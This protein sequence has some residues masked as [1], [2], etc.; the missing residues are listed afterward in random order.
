MTGGLFHP[1]RRPARKPATPRPSKSAGA[2]GDPGTE[3]EGGATGRR[4]SATAP[5][6]VGQLTRR[7]RDMLEDG[8]GRV[9]VEGEIT[10]AKFAPSGHLYFALRD[11]DA[12]IDAVCWRSTASRLPFRP[13][14]GD[15]VVA[16]GDIGVYAPRGRYQLV[17]TSLARAGEGEARARLEA[18]IEKLR[19]EGLFA[20]E[21][22]RP[23]PSHPSTVGVVTSPTGAALRDMLA[24]LR[25]RAPRVRV[26]VSPCVVQGAEAPASIRAALERLTAWGGADVVVVGRGGGSA[27]DLAAFND[28]SL[29]RALAA[30]PTPTISAVGHEVDVSLTDLVADRR[31]ATPSEAA[32]LVAGDEMALRSGLD[33]ARARLRRALSMRVADAGARVRAV[34]ERSVW[35]RTPRERVETARRRVDEGHERLARA[36]NARVERARAEVSLAMA[37]LTG[38]SPLAV[39]ARGYSVTTDESGRVVRHAAEVAPG[40]RLRTR[41]MDG[42]FISRREPDE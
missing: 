26:V 15:H 28:E 27:E 21:R 22:K 9:A 38:L 6:T 32:E 33:A 5:L 30:C 35:R 24:I 7:I 42:A 25:R 14:D 37:R 4:A 8:I 2:G 3:G 29:A 17:V 39:L 41:V 19:A 10:G 13:E 23:L 31:A 20:A 40:A 12:L 16:R 34:A 18:L 11:A 36:M 1:G